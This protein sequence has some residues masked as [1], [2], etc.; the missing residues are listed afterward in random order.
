MG[1]LNVLRDIEH[2]AH[3]VASALPASASGTKAIFFQNAER[4]EDRASGYLEAIETRRDPTLKRG[5]TSLGLPRSKDAACLCGLHAPVPSVREF[6]RLPSAPG[7][8]VEI[9]SDAMPDEAVT[10][11]LTFEIERHGD[12]AVVVCHG[13]M[14][15]G[16]CDEVYEAVKPVLTETKHILID[17]GD[18]VYVDSMGL[19]TLMRIYVSARSCGC[20][21]KLEHLGKQVRNVLSM[22]NLLSVFAQAESDN[23]TVA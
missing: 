8:S 10:K 5:A 19:A 12:S 3:L 11:V 2:L 13:R 14:I 20:G 21:M 1:R 17:L 7:T 18:V 22:T 9:R 23:I 16:A 15:H 4:P 6:W